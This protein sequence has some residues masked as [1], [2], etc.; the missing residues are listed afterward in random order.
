[1][2]KMN[3]F[4]FIGLN[5]HNCSLTES[6]NT[7]ESFIQSKKPHMIFTPT[8]ELIVRANNDE[9]LKDIYNNT[10]LLTIDSYVVYYAAR[11]AGRRVKQP[12][13][14]ARLMFNFLEIA[15]KKQYRIYLLGASEE[16]VTTTVK[17]LKNEYDGINIVGW[18]NGYFDFKNDSDI[19]RDIKKKQPDILFVAMS[20]PL[21]ENFVNKNLAELNVPVSI[22]VGG[23]FDIIAGKCKLAPQWVSKIGLEWFYRLMQEP[24]RMWKRYLVTNTKFIFLF[25]KEILGS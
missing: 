2:D 7:V 18:H 6:L 5:F 16:V 13:S 22:G 17:N 19:I 8:A 10:D 1:M 9:S 21:K 20:S 12:L 23:S 24:K 15:H 25:I 14:A 4:K 3:S 11:L